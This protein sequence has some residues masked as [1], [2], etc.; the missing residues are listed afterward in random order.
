ML[1]VVLGATIIARDLS[2]R[3]LVR[4]L[5][6]DEQS[7]RVDVI[8]L[9]KLARDERPGVSARRALAQ[10]TPTTPIHVIAFRDFW[11]DNELI[12]LGGID[13]HRDEIR[14]VS[15]RFPSR[16]DRSVCEVVQI[17]ERGKPRLSEGEIHLRRVGTG[18]L[19]ESGGVRACVH[20]APP[21]PCPGVGEDVRR[22]CSGRARR[23]SSGCRRSSSSSGSRAG[24]CRST[25]R[26]SMPG[27]SRASCARGACAGDP[28]AE[29]IRRLCSRGRM[30]RSSR[31]PSE[32]PPMESAWR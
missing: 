23:R 20:E 13:G 4:D 8:G 31:R 25:P 12:R 7:F 22:C 5:P 19:V 28:R 10:L 6:A 14:L 26:S 17:G 16:C 2:L 11:L 29:P 3:R 1:V 30:P 27:R 32:A 18:E 24:W 9:P 15:G 21:R